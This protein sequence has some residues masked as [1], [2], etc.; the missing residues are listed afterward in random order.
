MNITTTTYNSNFFYV[1]P[2]ISLNRDSN[3][4]FCPDDITEITVAPFL[5]VRMEKAGK[6]VQSKFASRYYSNIG[7]GINITAKS[8]IDAEHPESF[9]MANSLDNSTFV[10]QLYKTCAFPLELVKQSIIK[11]NGTATNVGGAEFDVAT[12]D[13]MERVLEMFN[14]KIEAVSRLSSFKTGD[15]IAIDT[16]PHQPVQ[17]GDSI[18]FV[19]LKFRIK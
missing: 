7:Y 12:P 14:Q 9:L 8:L 18:E 11:I 17:I 13:P 2:D 10:S 16:A 5:Y 6:A 15:Y 3:D 1:R 19:E 4:Y